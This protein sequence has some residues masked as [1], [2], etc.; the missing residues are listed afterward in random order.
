MSF[1]VR[2]GRKSQLFRLQLSFALNTL[3]EYRKSN[4]IT[5]LLEQW[6]Q[7]ERQ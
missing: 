4:D 7:E 5:E 2:P 3:Q 6:S 1:F